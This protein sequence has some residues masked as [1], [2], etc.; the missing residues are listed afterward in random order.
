MLFAVLR[1]CHLGASFVKSFVAAVL[2]AVLAGCSGGN[3]PKPANVT[4]PDIEK[5]SATVPQS[6]HF[7]FHYKFRVKD[8]KPSENAEQDLVQVWV[9]LPKTDEYQ[10]IKRLD[11]VA[12]V[13]IAVHQEKPTGNRVGY[14]QFAIPASGEFTI[15]LLYDVER[16]E[17]RP[18]AKDGGQF[19]LADNERV[20][21]L[22]ATGQATR[23]DQGRAIGR[24]SGC[25]R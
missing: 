16:R 21:F 20:E 1:A 14:F 5:S 4:S 7:V 18:A 6:R 13:V 9:P 12:P 15:D 2:L 25:P 17:V 19:Q 10:T 24:A 23:T 3:Q 11:E 8:L 22:A